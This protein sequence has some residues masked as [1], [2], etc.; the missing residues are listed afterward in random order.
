MADSELLNDKQILAVDDEEDV[1]FIIKE[2]LSESADVKLHLARTF[3][4]AQ[5]YLQSYT[6]DL[7][8]L[9]IMGVRGLD[10]LKIATEARFPTVML[11]AH[12]F[13]PETLKQSIELGARAYLPKEKLGALVPFLEDV[14]KLSYTAAWKKALDQVG[15][16]FKRKYG[17]DWRKSEQE[18]WDDF[19]KKMAIE[20]P[21]IIR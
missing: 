3:E 11:T 15:S 20:D 13:T 18:F 14:L 12:A 4:I 1:L 2:E 8:I 5:Q 19:E 10:L 7:V 6:Y 9:D 16:L 17:S 21:S